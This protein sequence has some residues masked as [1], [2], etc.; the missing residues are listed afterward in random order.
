[1]NKKLYFLACLNFL[2]LDLFTSSEC[3]Y[4][5]QI[6]THLNVMT[7]DKN[8]EETLKNNITLLITSF[9]MRKFI[10]S[11]VVTTLNSFNHVSEENKKLHEDDIKRLQKVKGGFTELDRMAEKYLD[12]ISSAEYIFDSARDRD[13]EWIGKKRNNL[14]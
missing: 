2:S 14:D 7:V 13:E 10:Q 5:K 9:A 3:I 4:K 12:Y 1:M 11:E 6:D 8:L